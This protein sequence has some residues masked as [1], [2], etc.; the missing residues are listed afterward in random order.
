[1][2][3][4]DN[5]VLTFMTFLLLN[6]CR[7]KKFTFADVERKYLYIINLIVKISKKINTPKTL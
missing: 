5:R 3:E 4:T 7:V 2:H 6:L 1:M